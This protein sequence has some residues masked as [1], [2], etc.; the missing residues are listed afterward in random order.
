MAE[1]AAIEFLLGFEI[2]PSGVGLLGRDT[3]GAGFVAF[4]SCSERK[5]DGLTGAGGF[6]L[7]NLVRAVLRGEEI[8]GGADAFG[9]AENKIAA[10]T[11]GVVKQGDDFV[12]QDGFEINEEVAA[13]DEIHL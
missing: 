1:Q 8:G 6:L 5:S 10:G 3:E 13:A 7:K 4:T 11:R 2:V 9:G 12:L